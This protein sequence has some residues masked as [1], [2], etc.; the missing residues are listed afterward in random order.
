MAYITEPTMRET[1]WKEFLRRGFDVYGE[2]SLTD[3]QIDLV[4]ETPN[5]EQWGIEVKNRWRLLNFSAYG[6][7]T[8][9][10]PEETD[11]DELSKSEFRDLSEQV[12]KYAETG[13]LD[14]IFIAT[15]NPQPLKDA[16]MTT[17]VVLDA[18]PGLSTVEIVDY[19]GYIQSALLPPSTV[20]HLKPQLP[21]DRPL[22]DATRSTEILD[23]GQLLPDAPADP[24]S[25]SENREPEVAHAC[26]EAFP[27]AVRE[28]V[29][30]N[31]RGKTPLRLD[32]VGYTGL[33]TSHQI[34]RKGPE[35]AG[36][37]VGIEAKGDV[38]PAVTT[39]LENYIES[40]GLT[41]LYLAVPNETVGRAVEILE[42]ADGPATAVGVLGVT[43]PSDDLLCYRNPETLDLD[44]GGLFVGQSDSRMSEIGWGR[45][46]NLSE[47]LVPA[48]SQSAGKVEP[49]DPPYRK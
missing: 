46:W 10:D 26:W 39:Q 2:V 14:R 31:R 33:P 25:I 24:L 47:Q 7:Y 20:S 15:Q 44:V 37:I 6:G 42:D 12:A 28:G 36:H 19:P 41:Q 1:L 9:P 48:Y 40:G 11:N 17:D 13:Q 38:T 3:G 23:H 35:Q 34:Y 16:F 5:G 8:T 30:P 43:G 27:V 21:N 45:A 29:V 22:C 18:D 49:A 4:V 32:V